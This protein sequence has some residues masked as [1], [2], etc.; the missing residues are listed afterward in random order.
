MQK[1]LLK[2]LC[3][4]K[5][6]C[7]DKCDSCI[8]FNANSNPDYYEITPDGKNIKIEQIRKM[9]SKVAEKPIISDKKV[10]IINDADMMT[11]EGQNC[12]LKT[13][14][15][16]P[17]YIVIILIVSNESK[18][19]STIKSRCLKVKFNNLSKEELKQYL[20]DASFELLEL[21]D[22]SLQN[23]DTIE[24]KKKNYDELL[25]I[26]ENIEK[27]KI[28]EVFNNSDLLYNQKS[29]II[30]LLNSMNIILFKK[31]M[32]DAISVVEK[33]KEKILANNNYEMCIDYLL[34]NI[35][36]TLK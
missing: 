13:L 28:L 21:L 34:M 31:K 27:Q 33:T 24:E 15:E 29:D 8:K 4:N 35:A 12:L 18:I 11:E 2:T 26:I 6:G 7:K 5:N 10:Y 16:P 17:E 23:V 32:L 9:Q 19:L 25:R 14:E 22:G 30:D 3:V 36:D 20:P 1:N